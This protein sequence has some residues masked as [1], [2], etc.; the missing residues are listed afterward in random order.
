MAIEASGDVVLG[1]LSGLSGTHKGVDYKLK[2]RTVI[3]TAPDCDI[4]VQDPRMSSHHCEV[5][6]AE[7]G[8]KMVDLG[9]TNGMLVN[10]KKVKEHYLVDNDVFRLGTTEFKF[11]SISS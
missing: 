10:D 1:W 7:G 8:F 5:R 9:S 3:G 2:A 4:V 6:Q 11:K